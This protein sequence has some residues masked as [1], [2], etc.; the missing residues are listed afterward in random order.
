MSHE[1]HLPDD[2]LLKP[3]AI[4][5]ADTVVA[6]EG[7]MSRV[8]ERHEDA[9]GVDK[10]AI[11][12]RLIK[13]LKP[14]WWAFMLVVLGFAIGAA[15][16]VSTAKLFQFIIDAINDNDAVRKFWFPFLVILLFIL[17]GVGSFLGSYYSALMAR[18]L[19]YVL[20]VEVF[21]KLMRLPSAYF[22]STSAGAIS[23]K[24][25]FDVEQVTA[26]ST[27]ALTV[28]LKD[29]LKVIALVGFL[30]YTNWR[31]TAVLLIFLPVVFW[32]VKRVSRKFANLSMDIQDSMSEVSHITNEAITGYHV[33]KGYGGQAYEMQRFKA[34]SQKN[35]DKG[36]RITI[37]SSINTP[38][39]QLLMASGMCFVIW[40]SLR[41][42]VLGST[43]AGEFISYLTAAG[44]LAAPVRALTDINQRLQRGIA[45]GV[46]IF[47]LLD[48]A[49][50]TD[51]GTQTPAIKGNISF[52][53]VGLRFDNGTVAVQD[54]SLDIKA[55]ETV[56]I[57]GRSGSGKSTLVNLLTRTLDTTSGSI[58]IDG[59]AVDDIRLQHLRDEIA[60]VNQQV[61]LF[62]DTVA[63][64]IA[65]GS[66]SH[67]SRDEIMMAA[68]AA[69][70]H[71]FIEK[72]PKGY[73]TVIGG[74][75][76]QLSGGQR[77]RLVIARALLKDAPIL[78]LDEATS[79]L[80]NES[81]HYIQKALEAV[82]ADRTTI[83]IAH[84]LSTIENADRIVVMDAGQV[85]EVGTHRELLAKNGA[86]AAM[87]QRN[88]DE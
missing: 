67:K 17:R 28:L 49:D 63:H 65:Y 55:G 69:F 40:L 77:Q 85:V 6:T 22:L 80:D 78:I 36:L 9:D 5:N 4:I 88:F 52:N 74:E 27:E 21:E 12:I 54:F 84:R 60:M 51:S 87:Y 76:V 14:Y 75:G 68:Q 24:L 62:M 86:Y 83:V 48:K 47:S 26:A 1:H 58:C 59:V 18:S 79:A 57:V 56:A 82:M 15:A 20:R 7:G 73:D 44:L 41:P 23:S 71:E 2:E 38:L 8:P 33:V 46:S 39:V 25:I 66:L 32:L 72:L 42:E 19:V 70:A 50:E 30:F 64:N 16:E 81:E 35:L 31:L 53:G 11:F 37:L 45:A 34:A 10:L 43:T 61:T 13:Y 3:K 29:G